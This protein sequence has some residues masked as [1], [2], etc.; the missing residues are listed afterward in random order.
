MN[1]YAYISDNY[2]GLYSCKTCLDH[3][4]LVGN[5]ATMWCTNEAAANTP[6]LLFRSSDPIESHL[7]RVAIHRTWNIHI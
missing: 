1:A 2:T 3:L 6:N 5:E 4:G 7:H